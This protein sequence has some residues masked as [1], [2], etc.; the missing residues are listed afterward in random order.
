MPR[1]PQ[2]GRARVCPALRV[3]ASARAPHFTA[4]RAGRDRP[5][6]SC[7]LTPAR[8]H[9]L[10]QESGNG[11]KPE[12]LWKS[13]SDNKTCQCRTGPMETSAPRT[14]TPGS[15]KSRKETGS[16]SPPRP[17][18]FPSGSRRPSPSRPRR[19]SAAPPRGAFLRRSRFCA[20][21]MELQRKPGA[22]Q[23]R[24]GLWEPGGLA[25]VC[26]RPRVGARSHGNW[27]RPCWGLAALCS[28]GGGVS[29]PAQPFPLLPR[30]PGGE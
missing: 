29:D 14:Q 6:G 3:G 28:P 4:T 27:P 1:G 26:T 18:Q 25:F 15:R 23:S 20:E 7:F 24:A 9:G 11:L 21:L 12:F 8:G 30:N 5:A 10:S 13:P 16:E 22:G 2:S 17:P 19:A